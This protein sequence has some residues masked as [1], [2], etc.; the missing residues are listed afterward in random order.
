M[1]AVVF[2]VRSVLSR[3]LAATLGVTLIVA[4]VCGVVIAFAAGAKRTS[5][6]PDRYTSDFG[7]VSD[8]HV[9]QDDR[10]KPLSD[11]VAALT[12]VESVDS[13]SFVFGGL[14]DDG[15]TRFANAL[16]FTGSYRAGGLRL[17]EGRDA[18]P[19]NEHEF[20]GTRHFADSSRMRIGDQ[21]NLTTL[22]AEE[23]LENG[24]DVSDPQGPRL[25]ITMVGIA[26]GAAQ[27]D[28]GTPL[29]FVSPAL[30]AENIGLSM[31]LMNVDLRPGVD[32]TTLRAQ[33]DGTPDSPH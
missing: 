8:A 7:G 10:G 30:L 1:R 26:D 16:V 29:V 9:T 27:L 25:S 5:T 24:F 21:V 2:R 14:G 15:D 13:T 3:R 12:G 33:L 19:A 20:V 28:D 31:T 6:S 22:T 18:D 11:E 32:L 17:V 23:A 4:V